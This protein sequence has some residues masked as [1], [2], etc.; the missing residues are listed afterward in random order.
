MR[1]RLAL[2]L[3][4]FAV[5]GVISTS[6]SAV[7]RP[8]DK[9]HFDDVFTSDVYDCDG[10]PAQDAVDVRVNFLF[11]Q[12]G[13]SPFPFYVENV[14][15]TVV[16]TNL[17]TGGTYTKVSPPTAGTTPSSTT[18]TAPSPSP[19]TRRAPATTTSSGA[20]CSRT[21]ARSGSPSCSTTT[22]PRRPRRRHRDPRLV[23]GRA[24]LH[25]QHRPFRPGLLRGPGGVHQ[26]A[27]NHLA[28]C[29]ARPNS[30]GTSDAMDGKCT[31]SPR[32]SRT[33]AATAIG[34]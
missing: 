10:T 20:S 8:I 2:L 34:I 28:H 33:S 29:A 9:G 16:T 13:S 6:A 23:P 24:P 22:A 18:A 21:P 7:A 25:W 5:V 4:G 11:N 30:R 27:V 19:C 3:T 17:E 1:G 14:N 26:L 12:R 32:P 15:G 31:R